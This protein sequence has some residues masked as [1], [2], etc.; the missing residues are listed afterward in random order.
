[1]LA[2]YLKEAGLVRIHVVERY[3]GDVGLLVDKHGMT[4]TE[5]ATAHVLA[6]QAHV[7]PCATTASQSTTDS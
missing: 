1:L 5:R 6:T 3:V 4:L 7:E 2:A